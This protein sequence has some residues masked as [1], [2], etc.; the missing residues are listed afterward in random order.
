MQEEGGI[1]THIAYL[2]CC[3]AEI[4]NIVKQLYSNKKRESVRFSV[5]SSILTCLLHKAFNKLRETESLLAKKILSRA[6]G[7]EIWLS[8]FYHL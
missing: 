8:S 1:H 2:R 5:E 7:T 4:N 3:T 6:Q